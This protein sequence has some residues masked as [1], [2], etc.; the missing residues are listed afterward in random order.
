MFGKRHR[1]IH[2]IGKFWIDGRRVSHCPHLSLFK[3]ETGNRSFY[4]IHTLGTAALSTAALSTAA[5]STQII[6]IRNQ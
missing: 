2:N 4:W 1:H 3:A 6:I 5:L